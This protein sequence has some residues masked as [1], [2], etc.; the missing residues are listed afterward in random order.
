MMYWMRVFDWR[1]KENKFIRYMFNKNKRIQ[2]KWD[3]IFN[4]RTKEITVYPW[5]MHWLAV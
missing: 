4:D 1:R 2:K 3:K 5:I